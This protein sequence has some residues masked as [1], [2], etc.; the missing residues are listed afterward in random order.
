[1]KK[2][3]VVILLFFAFVL[4]ADQ[5]TKLWAR[6]TLRNAPAVTVIDGYLDLA[7]H[8]NPGIAFGLFR[9]LPGRRFIL[10][11]LGLVVL[12][13]V[14]RVVRQIQN[15]RYLA[16]IAF[17]VVA[18]GAIGNMVDRIYIGRVVDFVVMHWQ[19]RYTWP[20]YNV[21]D[22][23]LCVG[24]GLLLLAITGE[25]TPPEQTDKKKPKRRKKR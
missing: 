6:D 9:K 3:I 8:E 7:Y 24:V 2:R 12:V 5:I 25:P 16:G 1:M 19:H 15:R 4:G 20:A 10:T 23:A 18:G 21:A 17:A 13:I 14:W 11:G 22:A